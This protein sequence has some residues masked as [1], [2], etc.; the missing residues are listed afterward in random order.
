[1]SIKLK[2]C[3]YKTIEL[4]HFVPE[5]LSNDCLFITENSCIY[6]RQTNPICI[7]LPASALHA[8]CRL[9]YWFGLVNVESWL[10][11]FLCFGWL[12]FTMVY[13]QLFHVQTITGSMIPR[14]YYTGIN[15][16]FG[17]IFLVVFACV[18]ILAMVVGWI[19]RTIA[20]YE[21]LIDLQ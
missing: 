6:G 7:H 14:A 21:N 3:L 5:L 12:H 17:F 11:F 18:E 10:L 8:R 16:I 19:W 1:M 9:P 13:F 4:S 2:S 15:I 20:F